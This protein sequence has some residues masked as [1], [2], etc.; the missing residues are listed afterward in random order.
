MYRFSCSTVGSLKEA[1][2]RDACDEYLRRLKPYARFS[3][4]EV[5]ETRFSKATDRERVVQ[6]E[7]ERLLK[8]APH[9]AYV[10]ALA[11]DGIQHSSEQ[12]AKLLKREGEG[13]RVISF[14]IGGPLGLSEDVLKS[15]HAIVSL[16]SLTFTHQL[17]RVVLLEQVYRAMTIV[18]DKTYHY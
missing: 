4:T 1:Y 14:V 15:A 7:G 2:W 9:G 12:F 16:S 11:P 8:I 13:G 3:I 5:G 17:A 18:H 6:T 10:I